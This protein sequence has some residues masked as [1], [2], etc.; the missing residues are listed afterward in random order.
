MLKKQVAKQIVNL[1]NANFADSTPATRTHAR[2]EEGR[3]LAVVIENTG[4]ENTGDAFYHVAEVA[5]I[6]RAFKTSCL[7][8]QDE[9][10]KLYA[11]LF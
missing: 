5:D 1:W 6:A 7:I 2:I 10:C 8:S 11:R 9:A 4:D 3:Y